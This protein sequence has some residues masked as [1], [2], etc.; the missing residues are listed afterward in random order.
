MEEDKVAKFSNA[1]STGFQMKVWS[2][3][4][5]FSLTHLVKEMPTRGL[6]TKLFAPWEAKLAEVEITHGVQIKNHL[7]E[8]LTL[9]VRLP[10]LPAHAL[11]E[12]TSHL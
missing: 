9:K 4:D 7:K 3:R 5:T 10:T 11:L 8:L 2:G 12:T 1:I 6:M